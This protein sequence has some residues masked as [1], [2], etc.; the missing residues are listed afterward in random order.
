[1]SGKAQLIKEG[2][3][4]SAD[5]TLMQNGKVLMVPDMKAGELDFIDIK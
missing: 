3:K 5:I 2:Y 4:A 1:M